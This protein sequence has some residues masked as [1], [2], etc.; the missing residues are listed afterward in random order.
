MDAWENENFFESIFKKWDQRFWYKRESWKHA[1]KIFGYRIDGWHLAKTCMIICFGAAVY[2][3][4][5]SQQ[6]WHT[7]SIVLNIVIDVCVMGML[8]NLGFRLF[9]HN[10]FGVK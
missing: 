7:A 4:Q 2:T 5:F 6:I 3:E 10:L 8:W 1:K 9:Y